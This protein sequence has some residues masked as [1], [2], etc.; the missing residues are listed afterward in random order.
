MIN[1][2]TGYGEAQGEV[3]DVSY[4]VEIKAVNNRYFKAII[5]LPDLV[6]FLEEDVERLL[7]ENLSRGTI[8]YVLRLKDVSA[9]ALFDIDET[10]LQAIM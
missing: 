2:M 6:A 4:V 8:N 9:T 10:A 5:K 3:N 7:R 1:S